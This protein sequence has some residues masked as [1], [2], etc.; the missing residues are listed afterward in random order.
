M[1]NKEHLGNGVYVEIDNNDN[2][3]LT[4]SKDTNKNIVAFVWTDN[5]VEPVWILDRNNEIVVQPFSLI[6]SAFAQVA[7]HE[8][9]QGRLEVHFS[10]E[11]ANKN[12][13]YL[14][15]S[16]GPKKYMLVFKR[17]DGAI[18][19]LKEVFVKMAERPNVCLCRCETTDGQEF[20]D[21]FPIDLG[22]LAQFM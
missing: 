16:T 17:S 22:P 15:K 2:I 7:L 5:K 1:K 6:E 20:V 12:T 4:V 8:D 10:F 13:L 14:V 21:S 19:K 18:C 11:V 9:S 3:I